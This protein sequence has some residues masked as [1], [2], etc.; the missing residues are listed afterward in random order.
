[1]HRYGLMKYTSHLLNT[2]HIVEHMTDT[3]RKLK[4]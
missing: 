1:M 2:Y 3:A 4:N